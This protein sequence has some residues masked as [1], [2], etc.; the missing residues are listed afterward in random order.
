MQMGR[1]SPTQLWIGVCILLLGYALPLFAWESE[2]KCPHETM[3]EV[4][5]YWMMQN[6][7]NK[8]GFPPGNQGWRYAVYELGN[9][10]AYVAL[11]DPSYLAYAQGWAD[12]AHWEIVSVGRSTIKVSAN[13]NE[14]GASKAIDRDIDTAWEAS[15]RETWIAFELATKQQIGQVALAWPRGDEQHAFFRLEASDDGATWQ[16][17]YPK[18][19]EFAPSSGVSTAPAFFDFDDVN[20]QHIR[21][22]GNGN[23]QD[24]WNRLAEVDLYNTRLYADN[25]ACG[26]VYLGLFAL[27][28]KP[29]PQI[30]GV[31]ASSHD[32]HPPENTLDDQRT[33]RWAAQGDGQWIEFDLGADEVIQHV[34]LGW[35]LGD[36][37]QAKFEL[38]VRNEQNVTTRVFPLNEA[39]YGLSPE[40]AT[41]QQ[42][43]DFP[44]VRARYVRYVGHGN[45]SLDRSL[46]NSLTE[47]D[48]HTQSEMRLASMKGGVDI[49]LYR[50][51]IDDWSWADAIFM[52]APVLSQLCHIFQDTAYCAK[53]SA[54]YHYT[55]TSRGSRGLYD[56]DTGLWYQS[57]SYFYPKAQTPNGQKIFW[58]RGNGW[59]M[60]ALARVLTYLPVDDPHR[61]EYIEMLRS[62]AR[63]LR[64]RQRADGFWNVSLDDPRHFPGPETSGTALF[65]YAL[66]WGINQGYLL[67]SIYVPVVLKA[68]DG[69]V[70]VAVQPGSKLGYVQGVGSG[71]APVDPDHTEPYGVGAFLL[72]G[73]EVAKLQNVRFQTACPPADGGQ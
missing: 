53:L 59:V 56:A 60:A 57:P 8:D 27:A 22:V 45:D 28:P 40:R 69:M 12:K 26:Q 65:T 68:W 55:K 64:T 25:L 33:T 35:Y 58:S 49:Q 54:M 31:R 16:K 18:D 11:G 47:V 1:L 44:D 50:P 7:L 52:E 20:V 13:A 43:I 70:R 67:P 48:I 23:S 15:G 61:R 38:F 6:P 30:Q 62:M 21:Y 41:A 72:A 73:S 37:R 63:A 14:S 29:L 5:G 19:A 17:V 10:A 71:P 39:A 34:S 66:A 24:L 32:G 4:N 2:Q 51:R 46:L 36:R 42:V 9:L 3:R